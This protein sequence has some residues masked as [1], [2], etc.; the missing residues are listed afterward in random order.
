MD[1]S[2]IPHSDHQ[3]CQIELVSI[4]FLIEKVQKPFDSI[5]ILIRFRFDSIYDSIRN[6]V[7]PHKYIIPIVK[8]ANLRRGIHQDVLNNWQIN[9]CLL[10]VNLF[11]FTAKTWFFPFRIFLP[12]SNRIVS[13]IDKFIRFD[14]HS[15]WFDSTKN[16]RFDNQIRFDFD[17][18]WQP[19]WPCWPWSYLS[20]RL[21]Q[22][23]TLKLHSEYLWKLQKSTSIGRRFVA[24][25][26]C[27]NQGLLKAWGTCLI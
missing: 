25:D 19:C 27:T 8:L 20:Q 26:H 18:I 16:I 17:S 11:L 14:V 12:K 23:I 24:W 21:I 6:L 1:K 7:S 13:K 3:G 9:L 10:F 5:S 4:R 2:W 15:I 22:D